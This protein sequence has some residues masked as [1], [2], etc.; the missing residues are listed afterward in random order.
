MRGALTPGQSAYAAYCAALDIAVW[1]KP[2]W[3]VLLPEVQRAWDAVAQALQDATPRFQF[4]LGQHVRRNGETGLLWEIWWRSFRE[5]LGRIYID[6]GLRLVDP[7]SD[8][9][10]CRMSDGTDLSSAEGTTDV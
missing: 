3:D 1:T 4:A 8:Y 7:A 6:Y 2:S 9:H 10:P 5:E